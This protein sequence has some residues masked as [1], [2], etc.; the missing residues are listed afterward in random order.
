MMKVVYNK[1]KCIYQRRY[2]VLK[3]NV[4]EYY[5][6]A[7][8]NS[9]KMGSFGLNSLCLVG[10]PDENVFVSLNIIHILSSKL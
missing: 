5:K 7:D 10:T 6:T 3:S 2:F 9:Q 4:I 8:A 1:L